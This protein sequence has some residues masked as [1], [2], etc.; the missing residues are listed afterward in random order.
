[1][2]RTFLTAEWRWLAML[3]YRIDRQ[4]LLPL[5]PA[6]TELDTW[7]GEAIV[8]VV[9]FRFL[10]TSVL[11]VPVP[12]HRNF[13]EVNLRFYVRRE[14]GGSLRRGVVFIREVVPRWA[15]AALAQWTYNE[16][17]VALPMKSET[18]PTG[19]RYAWEHAGR[20]NS[21]AVE[22]AGE[23]SPLVAG[24]EAEFITEHYWGY[25]QQRDGG[26]VEYE[27]KHP[28]WRVWNAKAATLACDVRGFYGAA[29]A[30]AL[31]V[32]PCSAFLAEGSEIA[33]MSARRIEL[34]RI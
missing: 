17:Y 14:S 23:P 25:T 16:P 10:K 8:S 21:I 11:G 20:W 32:P 22:V 4:V 34:Q 2:R 15:I 26:T 33:V 13:D 12:F 31:T 1:M 7:R 30:E 19:A 9:G 27:V 5:V 6:G 24:S 3:N 29:Y 28:P 18:G